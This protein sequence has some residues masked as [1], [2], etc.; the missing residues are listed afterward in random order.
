MLEKEKFDFVKLIINKSTSSCWVNFV[1][2]DIL[3]YDGKFVEYQYISEQASVE[4]IRKLNR[5]KNLNSQ[6]INKSEPIVESE[7][8]VP[9]SV[10]SKILTLNKRQSKQLGREKL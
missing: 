7:N 9:K 3:R 4:D 5:K 1:R 6:V 2:A 10:R 8:V